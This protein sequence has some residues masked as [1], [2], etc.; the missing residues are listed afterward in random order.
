[1][2]VERQVETGQVRPVIGHQ[3]VDWEV[4]L[5]NHH[6]IRISV[7][8]LSP[9]GFDLKPEVQVATLKFYLDLREGYIGSPMLSALYG[10]WAAYTGDRALSAEL[11]EDGY[12]RFCVG[13]FMQ[14][15]EYRQDVFSEQPRAGPFFA[16]LSRFHGCSQRMAGVIPSLR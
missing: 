8:N 3:T 11:M 1:M 14:T 5:P 9:L 6:P 16:N 12:G 15:L 7:S 2:E 13:R 10:V 4:S